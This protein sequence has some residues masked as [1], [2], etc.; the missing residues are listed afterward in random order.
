MKKRAPRRGRI[1]VCSMESS[2]GELRGKALTYENVRARVLDAGR[3]SS[4]EAERSPKAARLYSAL[5][6]DPS[7]VVTLDR[8]PWYRVAAKPGAA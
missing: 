3:F 5:H 1:I 2:A 4:F 7:I 8:Y 6:N